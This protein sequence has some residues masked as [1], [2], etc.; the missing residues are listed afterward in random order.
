MT[1]REAIELPPLSSADQRLIDAYSRIGRS[2]DELAYTP[3]FDRLCEDLGVG[4]S[5]GAKREVFLR[6]L[7]LRKLG[8]L[9]RRYAASS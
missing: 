2:V 8:R 6:L 4:E 9:P 7:T 5:L 1:W 3:D